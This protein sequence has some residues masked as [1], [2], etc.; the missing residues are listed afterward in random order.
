MA[1]GTPVMNRP[2]MASPEGSV[3][4]SLPKTTPPL[5]ILDL[6]GDCGLDAKPGRPAM[7]RVRRRL[8]RLRGLL[9]TDV[10]VRLVRSTWDFARGIKRD[11]PPKRNRARQR[12]ERYR[13]MRAPGDSNAPYLHPMTAAEESSD[14]RVPTI[15]TEDQK[16]YGDYSESTEPLPALTLF[17]HDRLF[18]PD[19]RLAHLDG[20]ELEQTRPRLAFPCVLPA[21]RT[22]ATS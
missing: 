2:R 19:K 12:R 22:R 18:D 13:S 1:L 14:V 11:N 15:F 5:A 21:R 17:E 7:K 20:T 10:S 6:T 3:E 4:P 9:A 16:L 8:R